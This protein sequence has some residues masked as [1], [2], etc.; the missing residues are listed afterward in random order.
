MRRN[1]LIWAAALVAGIAVIALWPLLRGEV[2]P[3]G[4]GG[5]GASVI[6]PFGYFLALISAAGLVVS[7]MRGKARRMGS[8]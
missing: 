6:L 3:D 8:R 4:A 2:A 5:F 1:M 7:W